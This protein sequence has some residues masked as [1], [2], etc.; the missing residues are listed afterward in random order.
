MRREATMIIPDD[1]RQWRKAER[2]R[3][4]ALRTAVAEA[5]HRRWSA[6]ITAFLVEGF[7]QLKAMTIGL[8]WPFKGEFDARYAIHHWRTRGARAAL[9]VVVQKAAPLQF[10]EWWPGAPMGKGV[11]DL[12]IP[13]GTQVVVPQA[14]L[15]PPIGFDAQGYRL[16]YGGGY[17]DRTLAALSPQPLKIGVAFELSRIATIHPQPHDIPMDY[18][19]T[20][21]GIH[22]V[23]A[24]GL[25]RVE[26][27]R[28]ATGSGYAA[29]PFY[30]CGREPGTSG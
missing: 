28:E 13:E 5:D 23:T 2:A 9:P 16:G 10:R 8:Y 11:F 26:S 20:Q 15:I 4:L 30:G 6:A 3:L 18:I 22:R 24:G 12:P 14:L 17:F 25:E 19:V 21:A 7:P 27:T 29:S 1:I